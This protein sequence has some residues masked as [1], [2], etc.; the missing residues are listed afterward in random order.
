M[1]DDEI[2]FLLSNRLEEIDARQAAMEEALKAVIS[3][4]SLQMPSAREEL[5]SH[6]KRKANAATNEAGRNLLLRLVP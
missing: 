2:P 5:T 3:A 1:D 6:I 4:I